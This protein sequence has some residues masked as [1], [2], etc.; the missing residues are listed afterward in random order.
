MRSIRQKRSSQFWAPTTALLV[1]SPIWLSLLLG[2]CATQ[3]A[4]KSKS[5]DF[6]KGVG[7]VEVPELSSN[8]CGEINPTK[9]RSQK[10]PEVMESTSWCVKAKQW[11]RVKVLARIQIETFPDSPWGAYFLSL[12]S[13]V[14][15]DLVNA[16]WF[17]DLSLKKTSES[18]LLYYQRGRILWLLKRRHEAVDYLEK[19]AEKDPSLVS[20]HLILGQLYYEEHD[21]RK[22]E[23]YFELVLKLRPNAEAY[24]GL[25]EC[26][27]QSGDFK[28]ALSHLDQAL[29]F[30]GSDRQTQARR[31]EILEILGPQENLRAPSSAKKKKE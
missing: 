6:L 17:A 19:A 2:G 26:R 23:K 14:E 12:S 30:G 21:Y 8:G 7:P 10:W 22:A 28:G 18:A 1:L 25:A 29:S 13:E 20:A 11:E 4:K 16:L 5:A 27:F 15:G 24:R 3:V 9:I 31:G